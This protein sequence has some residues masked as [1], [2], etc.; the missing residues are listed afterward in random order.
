VG[1]WDGWT[2]GLEW[3]EPKSSLDAS[4]FLGNGDD[5][6]A[7]T[8]D[9]FRYDTVQAEQWV[10]SRVS[11]PLNFFCRVGFRF[12]ILKFATVLFKFYPSSYST[13]DK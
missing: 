11:H 5:G 12:R 2:K 8:E 10:W 9:C 4:F 13:P 7:P 3:F 6:W 1:G